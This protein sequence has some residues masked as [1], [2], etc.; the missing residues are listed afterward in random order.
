MYSG[1]E[2]E[3]KPCWLS[4]AFSL[5]VKL[6]LNSDVF[7]FAIFTSPACFSLLSITM[8][9]SIFLTGDIF[10]EN[11]KLEYQGRG[12]GSLAMRNN[13]LP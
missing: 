10:H 11:C 5:S 1:G 6:D 12:A 3:T 2:N 4:A 13:S 7:Y 9:A 8:L